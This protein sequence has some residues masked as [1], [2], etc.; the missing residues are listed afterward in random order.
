MLAPLLYLGVGA[1]GFA[2]LF[3]FDS[4]DD[5]AGWLPALALL[6]LIWW[7]AIERPGPLSRG[8]R[9]TACVISTWLV[10]AAYGG[11][12]VGVADTLADGEVG[13]SL[14]VAFAVVVA[15]LVFWARRFWR[16]LAEEPPRECERRLLLAVTIAA[17]V[18]F[19][20][21]VATYSVAKD[22]GRMLAGLLP[23]MMA[24]G[25]GLTLVWTG[26]PWLVWAASAD[27]R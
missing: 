3:Q 18:S 27:E 21:D 15:S 8:R 4:S 10:S 11:V 12:I 16:M 6:Q 2:I 26:L 24:V 1:L 9:V 25:A 14:L 20:L 17:V 23:A 7:A 19:A 13:T 5:Y 22:S